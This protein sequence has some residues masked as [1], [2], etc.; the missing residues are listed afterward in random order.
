MTVKLEDVLQL[1]R[2]QLG[3]RNLSATDR[4]ME[5]LGA[6]SADLVN[7]AAA[8]EDRFTITFDEAKIAAIRTPTDLYNLIAKTMHGT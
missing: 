6:E 8:A 7:L 4:L 1:V 3:I 5:D 2:S